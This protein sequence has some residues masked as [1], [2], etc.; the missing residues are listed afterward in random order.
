M[1][2]GIM[3]A[4]DKAGIVK[5]ISPAAKGA[6]LGA[7]AGK[8]GKS[9]MMGGKRMVYDRGRYKLASNVGS[10]NEGKSFTPENI[11]SGVKAVVDKKENEKYVGYNR[12]RDA[13]KMGAL[14]D[15]EV[16]RAGKEPKAG[17]RPNW[18]P[19]PPKKEK[20]IES[21]LPKRSDTSPEAKK[22]ID[23]IYDALSGRKR[24]SIISNP[25]RRSVGGFGTN[26]RSTGL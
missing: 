5:K 13:G 12:L 15:K 4:L 26:E 6:M 17:S 2:T 21:M 23:A 9:F 1:A 19:A 10:K 7:V 11:V 20:P 3:S 8:A 16:E 24:K 18:T 25:K 22:K 14:T